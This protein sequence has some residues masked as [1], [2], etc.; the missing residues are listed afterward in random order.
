MLQF[1]SLNNVTI[2]GNQSDFGGGINHDGRS[3]GS[4]VRFTNTIVA[5]NVTLGGQPSDCVT[6]G[7]VGIVSQGYNLWGSAPAAPRTGPAI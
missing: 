1:S 4:Y 5:G 2:T 7:G 6:S 3:S